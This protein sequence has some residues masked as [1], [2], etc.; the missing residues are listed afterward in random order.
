MELLSVEQ[1]GLDEATNALLQDVDETS[2][3][4]NEFRPLPP[5]TLDGLLRDLL[6]ER[7]FSSNAIEGNTLDL[8]ETREVLKSSYID[9][10][11]RREAT[12]A[13]NLGRAI[14]YSQEQ[15]SHPGTPLIQDGFLKVHRM[16]LEDIND[17]WAGRFRRARRLPAHGLEHG[18]GTEK[19]NPRKRDVSE[20]HTLW[21]RIERC[22]RTGRA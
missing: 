13:R 2:R 16:L 3:R 12:E 14:E 8:R 4:V 11:R 5:A 7:V 10:P 15:L 19:L 17:D 1:I 9:I 22:R 6:G 20:V 18:T 21:I